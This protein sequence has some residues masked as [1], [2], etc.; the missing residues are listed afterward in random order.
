MKDRLITVCKNL[1]IIALIVFA[2]IALVVEF[3]IIL[4][5]FNF[6][7]IGN[8]ILTISNLILAVCAILALRSWEKELN[9]KREYET[10]DYL[11][12]LVINTQD[13]LS[14]RFYRVLLGLNATNGEPL[15][16]Q[17]IQD[18]VVNIG[19]EFEFISLKCKTINREDLSNHAN[20]LSKLFQEFV[21]VKH[22]RHETFYASYLHDYDGFKTKVD[23][24]LI[25]TKQSCI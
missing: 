1:W 20:T 9:K 7:S 13:T 8:V 3:N 12:K 15:N 16:I 17:S 23:K 18:N 4:W 25:E 21:D 11:L 2:I 14:S 22:D 24:A 5:L 10:I 19:K 6:D